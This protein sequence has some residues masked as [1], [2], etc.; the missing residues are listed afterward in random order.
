MARPRKEVQ[1]VAPG[2]FSLDVRYGFA[3]E[4]TK[5]VLSVRVYDYTID[6]SDPAKVVIT[7]LVR[8]APVTTP[9]PVE[10]AEPVE[11][12]DDAESTDLL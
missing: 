2:P 7:G 1:P 5:T 4:Q 10:V 9:E 12:V 3:A 6:Q 11:V 8:P